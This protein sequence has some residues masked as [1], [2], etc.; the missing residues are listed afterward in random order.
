[1][2]CVIEDKATPK[3]GGVTNHAHKKRIARKACLHKFNPPVPP[4]GYPILPYP[5]DSNKGNEPNFF[6]T[7]PLIFSST[8]LLHYSTSA[9]T[10]RNKPNPSPAN[11]QKQT[12]NCQKMRNE[13]NY[14]IPSVPPPHIHAKRTQFPPLPPSHRPKNAKGIQS[15]N[16]EPPTTNYLCKTNPIYTR[17][18]I[19]NAKRTQFTVP[20][21]HLFHETNPI[22]AYQVSRHPIF[23]R[24]EPNFHHCHHPTDPKMQNEPNFACATPA[25]KPN[26]AKRTQFAPLPL[27]FPGWTF[28][29]EL[30]CWFR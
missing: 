11:A 19:K 21:P 20:P 15:T 12:A 6:T 23:M 28:C 8:P 29:R 7:S 22:T 2:R 1:M 5:H 13:P 24:N 25:Q 17:P 27:Y 3:T 14:R 18:T 9:P 4:A 26:Y 30:V 16:Y 10:M